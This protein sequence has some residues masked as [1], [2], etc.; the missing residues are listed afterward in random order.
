MEMPTSALSNPI[1]APSEYWK[2]LQE[3]RLQE[4]LDNSLAAPFG[5]KGLLL[6]FLGQELFVDAAERSVKRTKETFRQNL[7][8]PL[9]ELVCLVYL[10]HAQ[11]EGLSHD[12]VASQELKS[13]QF[14]K[15]PHALDAGGVLRRYGQDLE[16]FRKAARTLGGVALN[17][18]DAAY[19]IPALPKVPLYYL[20]WE[21]DAEFEPRLSILFD[22][23]VEQ[24]LPPDA[25]WALVRLASDALIQA[26]EPS[27]RDG[28]EPFPSC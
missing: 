25:L 24:H 20:L 6:N 9:V 16:A 22:R 26:G 19:R 4:V 7:S 12:L 10:L 27:F 11:P 15:G 1:A 14:F 21:G 18:A 13:S 3:R 8:Q 28:A 2:A 17:M 23:S 5:D